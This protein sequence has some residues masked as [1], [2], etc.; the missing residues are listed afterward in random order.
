[1]HVTLCC[2]VFVYRSIPCLLDVAV[3]EG[4]VCLGLDL[5]QRGVDLHNTDYDDDLPF[6]AETDLP[7]EEAVLKV[8]VSSCF[9]SLVQRSDHLDQPSSVNQFRH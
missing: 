2:N 5:L 4:C 6:G 8:R 3:R 1:M 9:E 7:D